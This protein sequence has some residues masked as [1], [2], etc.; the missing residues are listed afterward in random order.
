ML[1]FKIK[2]SLCRKKTLISCQCSSKILL[3]THA[4]MFWTLRGISGPGCPFILGHLRAG[5][6]WPFPKVALLVHG[7]LRSGA[8]WPGPCRQGPHELS[9]SPSLTH[10]PLAWPEVMHGDSLVF[11]FVSR[12]PGLLVHLRLCLALSPS[13][14]ST[15]GLLTQPLCVLLCLGPLLHMAFSYSADVS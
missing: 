11:L 13:R 4:T 8:L 1:Y 6:H 15:G 10:C 3:V 12:W 7:V 5:H 9:C 2:N 14:P